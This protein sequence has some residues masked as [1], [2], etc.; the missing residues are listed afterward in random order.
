[1]LHIQLKGYEAYNNMLANVLPL[2]TPLISEVRSK[3]HFFSFLKVVM[4]HVKLKVIKQRTQCKQIVHPF[5]RSQP[6]DVIKRSKQV[7]PKMD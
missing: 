7:I 6:P 2:H 1:M 4:F 5:I 3:C